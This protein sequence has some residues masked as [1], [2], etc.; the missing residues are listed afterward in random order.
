MKSRLLQKMRGQ[1][2]QAPIVVAWARRIMCTIVIGLLL[3]QGL[4][5][6]GCYEWCGSHT[7]NGM[8][9]IV[10]YPTNIYAHY[11]CSGVPY[12]YGVEQTDRCEWLDPPVLIRIFCPF[13]DY[14]GGYFLNSNQCG[15]CEGC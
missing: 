7:V 15:T 6:A 11:K 10:A 13:S 1:F 9:V 5:L 3:Q 2:I 8:V 12:C 14:W 4:A